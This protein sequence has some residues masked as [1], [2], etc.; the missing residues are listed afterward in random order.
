MQQ[1]ELKH[2]EGDLENIKKPADDGMRRPTEYTEQVDVKIVDVGSDIV[3]ESDERPNDTVNG[4]GKLHA[5][6]SEGARRK[7]GSRVGNR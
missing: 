5:D 3:C 4:S 6:E 2:T 7:N 1:L